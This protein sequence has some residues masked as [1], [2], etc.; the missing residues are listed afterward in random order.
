[1]SPLTA[2]GK[3]KKSRLE[4]PTQCAVSW[5]PASWSACATDSCGGRPLQREPAARRDPLRSHAS[6]IIEPALPDGQ[7]RSARFDRR[8]VT[9]SKP[10]SRCYDRSN[11]EAIL[12]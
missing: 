3:L 2:A 8:D 11:P 1:M 4:D 12:R 7:A 6:A 9:R 5:T 10:G